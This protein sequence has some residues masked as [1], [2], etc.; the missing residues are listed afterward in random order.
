MKGGQLRITSD[1]ILA[2]TNGGYDIYMYY[3]GCVKKVMKRPW[4][5]DNHPSFGIF[6]YTGQYMWKDAA[7]ED[8]GNAIKYV[9]LKFGLSLEEAK[10][11]ILYDFGLGGTQINAN[12]VRVTWDKP[13]GEEEYAFISFDS[14]KFTKR[15]HLFWNIAGVSEEWCNKYECWAVKSAAINR[16]RV[17]IGKDEIVFA[18]YCPEEDAVKLYFPDRKESRFRNNVSGTHLWNFSNLGECPILV[19]QKSMKDL[20]VTTLFTP[21]VFAVQSENVKLF[22]D[23]DGKPT[24][25]TNMIN[26]KAK[27][28][29]LSYGSDPDG[30]EKSIRISKALNWNWVNPPN[31]YLPET[32]DIYS[33]AA[34]QGLNEVE[35]LFKQKKII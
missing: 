6:P 31:K 23:D 26:A 17:P 2:A 33:L 16:K 4:G 30:K 34:N 25:V 27:S 22:I 21:C 5:N 20:I 35:K 14:M 32:N 15:H 8:S 10:Q 28:V 24:E 11:K 9:Q 18:Y 12:P 13:N 7:K 29:F 1:D 19:G 3:E